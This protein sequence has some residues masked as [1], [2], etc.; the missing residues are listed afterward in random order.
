MLFQMLA[1][2][3]AR[4]SSGVYWHSVISKSCMGSPWALGTDNLP[5]T[6]Q[7]AT[8]IVNIWAFHASGSKPVAWLYKNESKQLWFQANSESEGVI[9]LHGALPR[10]LYKRIV[11][12]PNKASDGPNFVP[13]LL[14]AHDMTR[15]GSAL[16]LKGIVREDCFRG[17]L[18]ASYAKS[19]VPETA[20]PIKQKQSKTE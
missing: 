6:D 17:D 13:V 10:D 20:H 12:P 19:Y 15:L 2:A 18:P 5:M 14:S 1:C 16:Q 9:K 4:Q 3:D 8:T 11:V 7:A